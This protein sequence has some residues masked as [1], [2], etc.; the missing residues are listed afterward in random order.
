MYGTYEV[1]DGGEFMALGMTLGVAHPPGYALASFLLRVL[2]APPLGGPEFRMNL[3]GPLAGGFAVALVWLLTSRLTSRLVAFSITLF[4]ATQPVFVPEALGAKGGVY[5]VN[6]CLVTGL[7]LVHFTASPRTIL[8]SGFM[9]GLATSLHLLLGLLLAVSV[10]F[11]YCCLR[12]VR[13]QLSLRTCFLALFI[14]LIAASPVIATPIRSAVTPAICWGILSRLD[15]LL[16]L[17]PWWH[18]WGPLITATSPLIEW[19]PYRI[20]LILTAVTILGNLAGIRGGAWRP[21]FLCSGTL[22]TTA[23]LLFLAK[24]QYRDHLQVALVLL[25]G[26]A[27]G[28]A[29]LA[30]RLGGNRQGRIVNCS[31]ALILIA[32]SLGNLKGLHAADRSRFYLLDD[33]VRNISAIAGKGPSVLIWLG[34]YDYDAARYRQVVHGDFPEVAL[35]H[36]PIIMVRAYGNHLARLRAEYPK[37]VMPPQFARQGIPRSPGEL[38]SL[39]ADT[40]K[41]N[42]DVPVYAESSFIM[43]PP[44]WPQLRQLHHSDAGLVLA[45]SEARQRKRNI[46]SRLRFRGLHDPGGDKWTRLLIRQIRTAL[47]PTSSGRRPPATRPRSQRPGG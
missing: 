41:A 10:L 13:R 2:L 8:K 36:A 11:T 39:L 33:Y 17:G 24:E 32:L 23:I 19:S 1:A 40:V 6:V 46:I 21:C 20:V 30:Q 35:L 34:D 26:S 15:G 42:S 44:T 18:F 3:L 43:E 27:T 14:L 5:F 28:F 38:D 31:L 16:K 47:F 22:A 9:V 4:V 7:L 45:Y 37:F 12:S 29:G 25:P